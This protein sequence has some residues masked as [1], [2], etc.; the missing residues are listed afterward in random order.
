MSTTTEPAERLYTAEDLLRMPKG[1]ELVRGKLV[2]GPGKNMGNNP[3]HARVETRLGAI[4][5]RFTEEQGKQVA[6]TE[7]SF[8]LAGNPDTI[9]TPDISVV[10]AERFARAEAEEGFFRGAPDLAIEILSPSNTSEEM[11][12]KIAEYFEAGVREVWTVS[13]SRRGVAVYR[14][15]HEFRVYRR[16][17]VLEG[18]DVLPG[19]SLPLIQ[20]FPT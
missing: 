14:A 15:N 12:N 19:F 10:S 9:R 20:L 2:G 18:G 6:L 13:A 1:F 3:R 8:V 7:C 16:T 5:E 11:D 17:D 4:L